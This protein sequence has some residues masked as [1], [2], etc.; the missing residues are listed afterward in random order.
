MALWCSTAKSGFGFG[1]SLD[2][3]HAPQ[4]PVATSWLSFARRTVGRSATA[5][6]GMQTMT[7][8]LARAVISPRR[9]G[10]AATGSISDSSGLGFF[11]RGLAIPSRHSAEVALWLRSEAANAGVFREEHQRRSCGVP[12]EPRKEFTTYSAALVPVARHGR[13]LLACPR[14][15]VRGRHWRRGSQV[16]GRQVDFARS[17]HGKPDRTRGLGSEEMATISVVA[18]A[19]QVGPRGDPGR[20]NLWRDVRGQKT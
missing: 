8:A 6:R 15:A 17:P 10:T 4:D 18:V 14:M 13:L 2:R 20:G 11:S 9:E 7:L 5:R 1:W 3:Q 19:S 16:V 12:C